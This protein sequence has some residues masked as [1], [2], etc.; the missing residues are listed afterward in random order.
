MKNYT[1]IGCT[2]GIVQIKFIF[3]KPIYGNL[4]YVFK[5]QNYKKNY[6][7]GDLRMWIF[8]YRSL[9]KYTIEIIVF[10]KCLNLV[11]ISHE[12][13]LLTIR[14]IIKDRKRKLKLKSNYNTNFKQ[15]CES[16]WSKRLKAMHFLPLSLIS[17]SKKRSTQQKQGGKVCIYMY[18]FPSTVILT[19]G[20]IS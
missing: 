4:Y 12:S 2:F 13:S 20:V 5:S 15:N 6:G 10:Y 3:W 11:F 19:H 16:V 18:T 14:P 17:Y 9:V 1:L 7:K 8:T